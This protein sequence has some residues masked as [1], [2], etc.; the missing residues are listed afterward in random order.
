[1]RVRVHLE[2]RFS[3]MTCE[4]NLRFVIE[5]VASWSHGLPPK[6][7]VQVDLNEDLDAF[8]RPNENEPALKGG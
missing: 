5:E 6:V 8:L 2:S 1:M 4:G 7:D 3:R